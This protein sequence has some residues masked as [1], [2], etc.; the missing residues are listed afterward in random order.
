MHEVDKIK[1]LKKI[2]QQ[3]RID[4]L[5]AIYAAHSWHLG[6]CFSV[7]EI[8]SALYFNELNIDS[9]KPD[10]PDR[11]RFIM[12]KGHAS[13]IWY[14]A[15]AERGF[16]PKEE[17]ATYR[18]INSH[19]QGHP[20]M[21]KVKGLDMTTGSLGNGLG[22]GAGMAIAAKTDKRDYRVYVILGDGEIDEGAVWEA[23]AFSSHNKLNNLVTIIDYNHLQID[24]RPNEVL[25]MEPLGRK[26]K[27]LGLI[28]L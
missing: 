2:A 17:L 10:W 19:L 28:Q 6:S 8:M 27:T 14:S 5:E 9:K 4:S 22:L 7:A 24:G 11:D 15:L 1:Y 3:L 20:D 13:A 21:K 16:F 18:Q 12:S 25:N 23:A 26:W